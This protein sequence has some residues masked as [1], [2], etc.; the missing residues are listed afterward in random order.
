MFE[1]FLDQDRLYRFR[2]LDASKTVLSVSVGFRRKSDAVAAIM[3]VRENAATGHITDC[4]SRRSEPEQ[5]HGV[6]KLPA[7]APR[8]LVSV[9]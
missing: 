8:R 7:V 5:K 1:I 2:L 3:A 6:R 4:S 9:R